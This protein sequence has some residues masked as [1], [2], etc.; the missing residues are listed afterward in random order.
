MHSFLLV[1][2][3]YTC[4]RET[5]VLY[6]NKDKPALSFLS[7]SPPTH[8]NSNTR[9]N[10]SYH[11]LHTHVAILRRNKRQGYDAF[12]LVAMHNSPLILP[13]ST[14]RTASLFP[15]LRKHMRRPRLDSP[16]SFS[17]CRKKF[18]WSAWRRSCMIA[19]LSFGGLLRSTRRRRRRFID[20]KKLQL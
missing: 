10:V 12:A 16:F 15:C 11:V 2:S 7:A 1:S 3:S 9:N 20:G 13:T 14:A 4:R 8:R 5:A 17:R 18:R 6:F 19:F